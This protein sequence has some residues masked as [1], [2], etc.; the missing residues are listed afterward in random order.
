MRY[1]A[2]EAYYR[3]ISVLNPETFPYGPLLDLRETDLMVHNQGVRLMHAFLDFSG[4]LPALILRHNINLMQ[5]GR[6][7][8]IQSREDG[9]V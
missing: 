1:P 3:S 2:A 4:K 7:V 6:C 9:G 5:Y 8:V